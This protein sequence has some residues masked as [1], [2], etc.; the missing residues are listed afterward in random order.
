MV[1]E[2]D[3]HFHDAPQHNT[4]PL[5]TTSAPTTTSPPHEAD[6]SLETAAPPSPADEEDIAYTTP[7]LEPML[8]TTPL[9][10]LTALLPS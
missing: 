7:P 5:D 6:P 2:N 9:L 4:A 8:T 10:P 1:A 3:E